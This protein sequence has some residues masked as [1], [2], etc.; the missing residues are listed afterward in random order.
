MDISNVLHNYR[1]RLFDEFEGKDIETNLNIIKQKYEDKLVSILKQVK[2]KTSLHKS[3]EKSCFCSKYQNDNYCPCSQINQK[4]QKN[5]INEENKN[6]DNLNSEKQTQV[7]ITNESSDKKRKRNDNHNENYEKKNEGEN[8]AEDN[9]KEEQIQNPLKRQ[10]MNSGKI[11]DIH[12][13]DTIEFNE[14]KNETI[15]NLNTFIK[16]DEDI[17]FLDSTDLFFNIPIKK[18]CILKDIF[19]KLTQEIKNKNYQ[20]V[21]KYVYLECYKRNQNKIQEQGF[22]CNLQKNFKTII[23]FYFTSFVEQFSLFYFDFFL[24]IV[25][26]IITIESGI[27]YIS[28]D[29]APLHHEHS[30]KFNFPF[31]KI[32]TDTNNMHDEKYNTNLD[33]TYLILP[34]KIVILNSFQYIFEIVHYLREKQ[35]DLYTNYKDI[36]F[37]CIVMLEKKK[38]ISYKDATTYI[39]CKN[40]DKINIFPKE[41][42][43]LITKLKT[44]NMYSISIYN[45]I[46]EN[47][48]GYSKIIFLLDQFF[49]NNLN[50]PIDRSN[51]NSK[52]SSKFYSKYILKRKKKKKNEQTTH[53]KDDQNGNYQTNFSHEFLISSDF[54]NISDSSLSLLSYNNDNSN[55]DNNNLK[56]KKK[57]KHET[58][59]SVKEHTYE[60]ARQY[61]EFEKNQ[62]K[63]NCSSLKRKWKKHLNC[64][65][66]NDIINLK[67]I[68]FKIAGLHN[69]CPRRIISILLFYYE[70][71]INS[72]KQLLPLFYLYSK[73]SITD[74]IILELKIK[75]N[76]IQEKNLEKLDKL[77]IIYNKNEIEENENK[78][79]LPEFLLNTNKFFSYNY[80]KMCSILILNDLLNLNIFYNN[81]LPNDIL[82]KHTFNELYKKYYDDYDNTFSDKIISLFHYYIP[83]DI[84]K[85][86][87]IFETLKSGYFE[88]KNQNFEKSKLTN[89]ENKTSNTLQTNN[90]NSENDIKNNSP[91]LSRTNNSNIDDIYNNNSKS[92][93]K[94]LE[95]TDDPLSI[96]DI[97]VNYSL[98]INNPDL[99]KKCQN[100]LESQNKDAI[101]YYLYDSLTN[102]TQNNGENFI[103]MYIER[104]IKI[105]NE[106]KNSKYLA[107]N[108]A[109]NYLFLEEDHYFLVLSR[110]FFMINQKFL[111]LSTL[112][113]LNA[114]SYATIIINH[115]TSFNSNPFMNYFVTKSLAQLLNYL[116]TP[117]INNFY[118]IKKKKPIK[119]EACFFCKLNINSS[120]LVGYNSIK[121]INQNK[122]H[123]K[124]LFKNEKSIKINKKKVKQLIKLYKYNYKLFVLKNQ[125]KN[126]IN[127]KNIFID[128]NHISISIKKKKKKNLKNKHFPLQKFFFLSNISEEKQNTFHTPSNSDLKPKDAIYNN[129]E[130][131]YLKEIQT[132]D[133]FF[134]IFL[135]FLKYLGYFTYIYDELQQNVLKILLKYVEIMT[136][137]NSNNETQAEQI[138]KFHPKFYSFLN[139]FFLSLNNNCEEIN[140]NLINTHLW[141]ILKLIPVSTRYKV[142]FNFYNLIEKQ[143]KD[144]IKYKNQ[145]LIPNDFFDE[146]C[147]NSENKTDNTLLEKQNNNINPHFATLP[148][149]SIYFFSLFNFE[150]IKTKIRK[151]IK[152]ATADIL[153]DRQ[154]V[155]VQ[156]MLSEFNF[157]INRN[158]FIGAEVIIQQCEL[159]DNNMIITL[160]E[161]IKHIHIFSSDIF[162]YKI[163]EKQQLL[164]VNT[165]NL[166]KQNN[167]NSSEFCADNV[168]RPKKLINLSLFSAIFMSKHPPVE[169]YPIL[170]STLK[171]I[172]SEMHTSDEL[173][174]RRFSPNTQNIDQDMQ[175]NDSNMNI[176]NDDTN[177]MIIL[178]AHNKKYPD[179]MSGYIFDLE[180]IQ[181]LIEIYGGTSTY[182]EVQALNEDQLDA[183][184]GFRNLKKEVMIIE[185]DLD[186]NINNT[187]YDYIEKNQIENE[188]L[189]SECISYASKVLLNP[190]IIYLMFCILSKLKHEY[191]YDSN[192]FN[193]KNLS[194]IVDQIN[195]I[196]LQYIDFLQTNSTPKL[197]ISIIPNI[198]TIFQFFDIPQA[199]QIIRFSFPFFDQND[200]QNELDAEK[201][202][203]ND[204][205]YESETDEETDPWIDT[206]MPIVE[207]YINIENLNG[208]NIKFYL[209]YWRL[210]ISDIYVPH[211]QYKKI[212]DNFD[213]LI[214]KLEKYFVD[215]K[216]H[217]DLNWIHKK[218]EKLNFRKAQI[219]NEYEYH[220]LHT[221]KI[222]KKLSHIIEHWV[223]PEE[224]D[225][226]TFTSFVKCLIAPRILNSEKDSLFCSKFIQV[227]VEFYTPLFN[228]C[229]LVQVLTKMLIPLINSCTEK[230]SLNV[231][232]FFNDLFSYLYVLCDDV[233]YFHNIS[234]NNP[235]FSNTLNFESKITIN[236]G[237]IVQK[238]YKWE[239]Y[240]IALLFDH[241]N[242]DEKT[243]INYKSIVVF[244]FRLVNSFPYSSKIKDSI[245][246]HLQ[247]LQ[248][249]SKAHGWKDILIS[250]NSLK[251]I[252]EKNKKLTGAE[253]KDEQEPKGK[254]PKINETP[255][256]SDSNV[257]MTPFNTSRHAHTNSGSHFMPVAK[258]I[259][260]QS[261]HHVMPNALNLPPK[262]FMKENFN[263]IPP[264]Q[265]PNK[266]MLKRRY[267]Y[268]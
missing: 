83:Y 232:I 14:H 263:K 264:P 206:M 105:R 75:N 106:S 60:P 112:I 142:Y 261:I 184:G 182:V 201:E 161:S 267:R 53:N 262:P 211:K 104:E 222:K 28:N 42:N 88:K 80:F 19:T 207:K 239:N 249:I 226:N 245:I 241:N 31:F 254:P 56:K 74:V 168:F 235:C 185:N 94:L 238:I 29:L 30:M 159:F 95:N 156:N 68:I 59:G 89:L 203:D 236:H 224:I 22:C 202:K 199:F 167:M 170:I 162:L 10:N 84:N 82:L 45:L 174:L 229:T 25:K 160:T 13:S 163:I 70:Q 130:Q 257:T 149:N 36:I 253:K 116:L 26:G 44:K 154:N 218:I 181:K 63:I 135:P 164:N 96:H 126:N 115:L 166:N 155:K 9:N 213:M 110:L 256:K 183:Q 76:Y 73:E 24:C 43:K 144:I 137:K 268:F 79:H 27:N 37:Q 123:L 240:I 234:N 243:W 18:D 71:N 258:N 153:K 133:E 77:K 102:N 210:H 176:K 21:Y 107:Y 198:I 217:G 231:G 190:N 189:K 132:M 101:K 109:H 228:L 93:N 81:L 51:Q 58:L 99:K 111:F 120:N 113:D 252:M 69:L 227:L 33:N 131:T 188:K 172:F 49:A 223:D 47:I 64:Y 66:C 128:K 39:E 204:Q 1:V 3:C 34:F 208:I 141:N 118:D 119:N 90:E 143:K 108:N 103:K 152:R 98:N 173:F 23:N 244:L 6:Q 97:V 205:D 157:I 180:Y 15:N 246:N 247:N 7:H 57:L 61:N 193:L 158:P 86:Y 129:N 212:I 259:Y 266:Y 2:Y 242:N 147:K 151:I 177:K 169:F 121:T 32:N 255:Q 48:N 209:I 175:I 178:K 50:S 46:R 214:N 139:F 122:K 150:L 251:Q 87:D 16:V 20:N 114:W 165:F 8:I 85:M 91:E 179:L 148:I 260:N 17:K 145:I 265:E 237:D 194:F 216:K 192:T 62:Q 124:N 187:E 65:Y 11:K 140:E 196:L 41:L 233:K 171:R 72:E 67:K 52:L 219:K 225:F 200:I 40:F 134:D 35:N 215:N 197:Y 92:L 136:K 125:E 220:I 100:I 4:Y 221:N 38:I 55:N 5:E 127:N 250:I 12:I 146:N 78:Y 138:D 54:E 191:L 248:N 186:M 230:E 195:S 117:L